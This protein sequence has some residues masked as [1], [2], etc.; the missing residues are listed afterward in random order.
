MLE[1]DH[2]RKESSSL[3]P[4]EVLGADI[5]E[6]EAGWDVDGGRIANGL[7][8]RYRLEGIGRGTGS[9]AYGRSRSNGCRDGGH[10]SGMRVQLASS[11]H[12]WCV[13]EL[14]WCH[15]R[16]CRK[17]G[18]RNGSAQ[19]CPWPDGRTPMSDRSRCGREAL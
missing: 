4:A 7:L 1:A 5:C 10:R 2:I 16:S 14:T 9:A 13:R 6:L 11:S 17:N 18:R 12:G 19:F 3:D 15:G 8:G